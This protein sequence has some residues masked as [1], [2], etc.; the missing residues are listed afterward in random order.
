[1][2]IRGLGGEKGAERRELEC[3]GLGRHGSQNCSIDPN[4]EVEDSYTM[5]MVTNCIERG[6]DYSIVCSA[7][8]AETETAGTC[9]EISH[10]F[11]VCLLQWWPRCS[12]KDV[13]RLGMW[14][15]ICH[16]L[17]IDWGCSYESRQANRVFWP[18]LTYFE[19][20]WKITTPQFTV[21]PGAQSCGSNG[22]SRLNNQ[23]WTGDWITCRDEL[24]NPGYPG[25]FEGRIERFKW[26]STL[27]LIKTLGSVQ[28]QLDAVC[29]LHPVNYIHLALFKTATAN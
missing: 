16:T 19:S 8:W 29:E 15:W 7:L 9:A 26:I 13:C 27:Y 18:D 24:G 17:G 14:T 1:M 21:Q 23:K 20:I 5:P 6:Y 3:S 22:R 28:Y 25:W 11:M 10:V 12:R 4:D 2:A